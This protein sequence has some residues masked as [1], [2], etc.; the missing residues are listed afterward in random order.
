MLCSYVM[1]STLIELTW[2]KHAVCITVHTVDRMWDQ[3]GILAL[4]SY[5][6]GCEQV[7]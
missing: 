5:L 4:D 7:P 6:C 3:E 1:L 2:E